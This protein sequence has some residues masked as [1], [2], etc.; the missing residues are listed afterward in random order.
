M[1]KREKTV[2][3]VMIDEETWRKFK[4]IAASMGSSRK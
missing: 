2:A 1:A 4:A 3:R